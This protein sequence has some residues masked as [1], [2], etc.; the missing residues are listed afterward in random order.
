[1]ADKTKPIIIDIKNIDPKA[2]KEQANFLQFE[3]FE[4]VANNIKI[5]LKK[6]L[7][8]KQ[9]IYQQ[10]THNTILVDGKRGTGKTQFLLNIQNYLK[11]TSKKNLKNLYFFNPIDPT[12]LHDN[13]SFLTIVIAKVLNDLEKKSYL[14]NLPTN[15]KREFYK[16]LNSLAEAIDGVI[17]NK[18]EI[19]QL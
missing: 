7:K 4:S 16:V 5:S 18:I 11:K 10:R 17:E 2:I 3:A 13:E 15:E 14:D 8:A 12:L 6:K 9:D 19:E 1:M